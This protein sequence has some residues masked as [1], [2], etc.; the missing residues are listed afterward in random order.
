MKSEAIKE[1][2]PSD[3]SDGIFVGRLWRHSIDV[4]GPVPVLFGREDV[5]DLSSV[6]GRMSQLLEVEVSCF[7]RILIHV[8]F[9]HNR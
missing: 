4:P 2:L 8:Q 3:F 7:Y 6:F 5:I 1:I 9:S